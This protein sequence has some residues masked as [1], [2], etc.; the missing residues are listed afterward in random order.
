M[1]L[2]FAQTAQGS[3]QALLDTGQ[4]VVS[5]MAGFRTLA[6]AGFVEPQPSVQQQRST[7]VETALRHLQ[8]LQDRAEELLTPTRAA[9]AGADP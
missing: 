2:S 9:A 1:N 4:V 8:Q 3:P 6:A 5:S 7:K